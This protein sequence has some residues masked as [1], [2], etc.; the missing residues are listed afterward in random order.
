ML[1]VETET[2]FQLPGVE[3][4]IDIFPVPVPKSYQLGGVFAGVEFLSDKATAEKVQ[5]KTLGLLF[6]K[7]IVQGNRDADIVACQTIALE[8][9][10]SVNHNQGV[11]FVAHLMA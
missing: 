11:V 10:L 8:I 6:A 3:D 4:T 7:V 5:R 2:D 1:G 9:P